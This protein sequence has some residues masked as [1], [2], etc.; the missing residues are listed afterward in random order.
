MGKIE[1]TRNIGRQ[2]PAYQ[3]NWRLVDQS[4]SCKIIENEDHNTKDSRV[5]LQKHGLE[6]VARHLGNISTFDGMHALSTNSQAWIKERSGEQLRLEK[7]TRLS[8]TKRE[9][10]CL[11]TPELDLP[12]QQ[13]LYE[14]MQIYRCSV[15]GQFFPVLD[16]NIF[17]WTVQAA[18]GE[19]PKSDNIGSNGAKVCIFALLALV[20]VLYPRDNSSLR[21]SAQYYEKAHRLLPRMLSEPVSL[22]GLQAV[23]LLVSYCHLSDYGGKGALWGS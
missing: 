6:N 10:H 18:Y 11:K 9:N 13:F 12:D 17:Q 1:S 23:L 3:S 14:Q 4:P 22:D 15:L 8:G 21:N 7:L 20:T 19:S 5:M 16:P 2:I